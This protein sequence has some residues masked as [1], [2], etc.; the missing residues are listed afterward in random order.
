M[1]RK[2]H[3]NFNNNNKKLKQEVHSC[4]FIKFIVAQRYLCIPVQ[5]NIACFGIVVLELI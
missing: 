5:L 2:L 1:R 3:N 4:V